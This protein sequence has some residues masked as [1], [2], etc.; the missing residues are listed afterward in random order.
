MAPTKSVKASSSPMKSSTSTGENKM[1]H[2]VH[3]SRA[4][5][6]YYETLDA[7]ALRELCKQKGLDQKGSKGDMVARLSVPSGSS[8][9]R[10]RSGSPLR[11]LVAVAEHEWK[12]LAGVVLVMGTLLILALVYKAV[13]GNPHHFFD[14]FGDIGQAVKGAIGLGKKGAAGAAS[15]AK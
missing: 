13:G 11:K 14:H 2:P 10:A 3:R 15:S 4:Y 6:A 5:K 9:A 7:D 12:V 1:D 8:A